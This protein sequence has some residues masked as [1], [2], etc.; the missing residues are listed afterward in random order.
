MRDKRILVFGASG[1][2][3]HRVMELLHDREARGLRSADCDISDATA[4]ADAVMGYAPDVIINCAAYTAV[5][6]AETETEAADRVNHAGPLN[7]AKAAKE[8]GALLIHVST[9]YVFDGTAQK[10]YTEDAPTAP[11]GAYG[12]TKRA[13]EEA[14]EATGCRHVTIR[15]QWLYDSRGKNFFLTM[16]RLFG[17]RDRLNVVNDQ[18]GAPTFA[19]DLARAIV[20][21]ADEYD[22]QDGIYQYS[23]SGECT[24]YDFAMSI[25]QMANAKTE[26]KPV[27]TSQYPTPA[28]RPHYSTLSKAK[29][30]NTFGVE[31]PH[32]RDGLTRCYDTWSSTKK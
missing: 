8:T 31:V 13:G 28:R 15:T 29:I 21:I 17:E 19:Y 12:A 3:G 32:W 10:P 20:K 9:D 4:V 27:S 14:I 2:L 25:A 18:T 1:M 23:N 11:L 16:L 30:I 24:W 5:D 6:K 7:L 26:I 22:G